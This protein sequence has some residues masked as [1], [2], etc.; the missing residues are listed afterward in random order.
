MGNL[1]RD[2]IKPLADG[3]KIH[4][5]DILGALPTFG[6]IYYVC[7]ASEAN[8]NVLKKLYDFKYNDGS[9]AFAATLSEA[10]SRCVSGRNDIIVLNANVIHELS[11]MLTVAKNRVHFVGADGG[12]RL[13]AQ[14]AKIQLGVT[15]N[16]LDISPILITGV[17]NS[18]RNVKIINANTLDQSLYGLI[19]NG[20][21]TML[22]N[23]SAMKIAGLDDTLH[24][25]FWM[26]GD[27]LNA[28]NV[29]FGQSN[30]PSAAAGYGILID[31]KTGGG[32][33]GT[34][35]ENILENVFIRMQIANAVAGTS[36]FIKVKDTAALNFD[37]IINGLFC[38]NF[39]QN[40]VAAMTTAIG[41][42]AGT[43]GGQLNIANAKFFGATGVGGGAT[44]G[45]NIA[46]GSVA[47]DANGG[48]STPLTD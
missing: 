27:S 42:A 14:G 15:T 38:S 41:G 13:S 12:G 1:A 26:A 29:T 16:V 43:V 21:A 37:N 34:V 46:G 19:D 4:P 18:F 31:G 35:K 33:D 36:H 44:C 25:H 2:F 5:S 10:Y 11:E 39:I 32:T 24:A 30:L 23:I 6:N 8:Y 45:I 7:P 17:R 47:P 9:K 20:E 28:K 40:G 22:E 48:L 3:L